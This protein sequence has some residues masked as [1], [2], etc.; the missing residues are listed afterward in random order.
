[1][2]KSISTARLI[3]FLCLAICLLISCGHNETYDPFNTEKNERNLIVIISDLHLGAD[4]KYA[5]IQDNLG[6][7]ENFL[8]QI[9][10][11][12]NVK[13]LVIAGDLLDEWFVPAS[14]DT[15]Q[16]R[17][18][19]DFM[20]R[21]AET[22]KGVVDA[23]NEIIEEGMILVTYTPGNHDLTV[24]AENV[25]KIFPGIHQARDAQA[26]GLGTYS[27]DN[28]PE[29]AIEHGHRYNFFCAPDPLSNQGAAPG[30][31]L[32]PGYFFTR[33]AAEHVIQKCYEPQTVP[34]VTP[35]VSNNESQNLLYVYYKIWEWTLGSLF[36]I[37]NTFDEK[38]IV[39]NVDGWT[40]TYAV[41]D[42]LPSQTTEGG[43]ISV[44]LFSGIQ[45]SWAERCK[46]NNV[47]IPI[48]A[49]QAIEQ[50]VSALQ[51]DRMAVTQYF[52][53]PDSDKRLVVFGHTH[54]AKMKASL[55]Y[56]GKKS[57]YVNSGT[58]IDKVEHDP[59]PNPDKTTMNFVIITPQD[60]NASSQTRV[61]LY[62]FENEVITQM[63][64][65]S[66]RF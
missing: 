57:L 24:T 3:G 53:N 33:I 63:A 17:D 46:L 49:S 11:S 45:D 60:E 1:M 43:L 59:T 56:D 27:P 66:L 64:E 29:I 62:N 8:Y 20:E 14:V 28:Y 44:N 35:N 41:N 22:N 32:P 23:F 30:T 31:I 42:L 12:R 52:M 16:G 25:D 26:F 10:N 65:D 36:H 5:E 39:T 55:N 37:E 7:L 34:L 2:K 15:Y 51:T 61:T 19:A 54:E 18:Q 48:P 4:I 40:D 58:W 6:P 9:K 38:I 13:E 47:P 21:I 50:V